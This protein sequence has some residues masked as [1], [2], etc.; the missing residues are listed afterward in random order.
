MIVPSPEERSL[1]FERHRLR[2]QTSHF[3]PP[4]LGL[5]SYSRMSR[6]ARK[7]DVNLSGGVLFDSVGLRER[8]GDSHFSD[9]K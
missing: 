2:Q 7:Q 4:G 6:G 1:R 5:G 9:E 8:A 3:H